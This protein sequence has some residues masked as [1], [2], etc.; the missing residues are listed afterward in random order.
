MCKH[1]SRILAIGVLTACLVAPGAAHA[2]SYEDSLDDCSYPKV[3]DVIVL[4]PLSFVSLLIG[5]ALFVP[6]APIAAATV[7]EDFGEVRSGLIGQPARFTFQ[8]PL[9]E[10]SGVKLAY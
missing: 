6:V 8:R 10:C 7:W 5:T 1:V 9:G 3:F 4:R 2:V